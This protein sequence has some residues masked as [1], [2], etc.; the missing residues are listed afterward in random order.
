MDVIISQMKQFSIFQVGYNVT[1]NGGREGYIKTSDKQGWI[2]RFG[3]IE[4][5]ED[6]LLMLLFAYRF[7]YFFVLPCHPQSQGSKLQFF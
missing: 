6:K 3:E 5:K 4:R 1:E 7:T 2:I